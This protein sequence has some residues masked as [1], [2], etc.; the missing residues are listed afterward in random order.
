M[1]QATTCTEY[2]YWYH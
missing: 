1:T 2:C